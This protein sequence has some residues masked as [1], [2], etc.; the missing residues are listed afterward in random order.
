[1][2]IIAA[3]PCLGKTTLYNLN[4][5]YVFDR[6]FCESRSIL[7]MSDKQIEEFFKYCANIIELQVR[8]NYH[9]ILFISEDDRLLSELYKKEILPILI[10]PDAF[11]KEYMMQY[12][13]NV[14][15]RSG[16]DWWNRV[17]AQELPFLQNRIK[18][19]KQ[20]GYDV[21]LTNFEK[22]Y[23]ENIVN[24]PQHIIVPNN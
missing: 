21:R 8:T 7:G 4:K 22:P 24:L 11:N 5:N 9:E 6:E 20:L 10:F 2:I 13:E 17:I 1:M 3:Y 14:I 23:I 19:Y 16:I 15:K 12:K 18:N